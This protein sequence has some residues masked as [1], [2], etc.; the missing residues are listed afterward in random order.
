MVTRGA[1]DDDRRAGDVSR[2]TK[3]AALAAIVLGAVAMLMG[4]TAAFGAGSGTAFA[5]CQ[6]GHGGISV[7]Y[8]TSFASDQG[9]ISGIQLGNFGADCNGQPMVVTIKGNKAGDPSEPESA[10]YLLTTL[11]SS[12]DPC[13]GA[14]PPQDAKIASGKITL[15][16]CPS[17]TD[18]A[19]PAYA[20]I[21]D[22]TLLTIK[23]SGQPINQ[24]GGP[25]TPSSPVTTPSSPTTTPSSPSSPTTS[26]KSTTAVGAQPSPSASPTSPANG[27][28]GTGSPSST[29]RGNVGTLNNGGPGNDNA[30][31]LAGPAQTSGAGAAHASG[32]L[33][34][35]GSWA[36]LTFWIGLLLLL[37]GL[38]IVIPTRRR[39][40]D[41]G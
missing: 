23:V 22:A 4:G 32:F 38:A 10:D 24:G 36:A 18:P 9:K 12:K 31:P 11:D 17:V 21:H 20:S 39:G 34:F 35:T 16:G 37:I 14:K 33:P 29:S 2:R 19:G 3:I 13:P 26:P 7:H 8:L 5:P 27:G 25:T 28:H 41:A 15:H 40:E 1:G 30:A 6:S